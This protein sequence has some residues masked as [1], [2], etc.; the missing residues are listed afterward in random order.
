L[1]TGF[2]IL[3]RSILQI[4]QKENLVFLFVS[5]GSGSA[6]ALHHLPTLRIEGSCTARS[7]NGQAAVNVIRKVGVAIPNLAK[8]GLNLSP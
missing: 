8:V 7:V 6:T 2:F 3:V 5:L 1:E 4:E